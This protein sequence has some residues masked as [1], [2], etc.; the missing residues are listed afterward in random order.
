MADDLSTKLYLQY[1]AALSS[2]IQLPGQP[3]VISPSQIWDWGGTQGSLAGLTF[4]QYQALNQVP[5]SPGGDGSTWGSTSGFDSIYN[6]WLTVALNPTPGQND[7]QRT[8]LQT[9]VNTATEALNTAQQTA[10]TNYKNFVQSTQSTEAYQAWLTNEG[11]AYSASVGNAQYNLTIAQNAL[12]AYVASKSSA[13]QGAIQA[14]KNGLSSV[15][16]PITNQPVQVGGWATSE[17][18]Y[19]YVNTITQNNPGGRATRGNATSFEVSQAT[20]SYDY[21]KTWATAETGFVWDFFLGEGEGSWSSVSTESF[22]SEY[23][24]KFSFGDLT[25]IQ[26]T[27]GSWYTAGVP[28]V[29]GK[30]GPYNEGFSGFQSGGDTYFFGPPAGVLERVIT[31]IV[32]GYQPQVTITA[33]GSFATTLQTKWNAEG[34]IIIGPFEF[35]ASAGGNSEHDTFSA[36]GATVTLTNNGSWPYIVA[37]VSNWVVPPSGADFA[38]RQA[39][40]KQQRATQRPNRLIQRRRPA[41][42]TPLRA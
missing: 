20:S 36:D 29:L 12:T 25:V 41:E 15:I 35:G 7:P 28:L 38:A 3:Q 31:A 16:S 27:P 4:P 30:N 40:G 21:Q 22:S 19:N 42:V 14:Y 2:A 17:F 18:A 33:G 13:V 37:F 24:L 8:Q 23:S 5:I 11:A 9:A 6:T 26:V 32:V 39:P 10:F 1:L 34:G